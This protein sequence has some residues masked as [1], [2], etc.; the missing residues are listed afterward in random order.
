MRLDKRLAGLPGDELGELIGAPEENGMEPLD[1]LQSLVEP[2]PAP[3]REGAAS[4]LNSLEN[5]LLG[6]DLHL[7]DHLAGSR[8]AR[9]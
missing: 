8:I 7:A 6:G 5:L 9:A 3:N 4:G 2:E 1:K